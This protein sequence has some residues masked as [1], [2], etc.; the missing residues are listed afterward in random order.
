MADPISI[1]G[2]AVGLA[3]TIGRVVK[4]VEQFMRQVREARADMDAISREL[5]SVRAALEMLA[6]DVKSVGKPDSTK[7]GVIVPQ[8]LEDILKNC[9]EVTERL[10]ATLKKY[11]SER[12]KVRVKYVWSGKETINGYRSTL[13]AH[14]GALDLAVD[15][16][17]LLVLMSFQYLSDPSNFFP[18]IECRNNDSFPDRNEPN[19]EPTNLKYTTGR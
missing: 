16:I 15:L 14:K 9:G 6:D 19:M 3:A 17:T 18:R 13:A 5:W 8:T 4:D 7:S 2:S 12:L 11:N 1:A 10:D